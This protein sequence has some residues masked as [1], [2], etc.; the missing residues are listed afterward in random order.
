VPV[1][2]R[3]FPDARYIL[4]LRH[5]CD[6]LL[7]CF[8]TNFQINNAMANFLDLGDAA[9]LYDQTFAY[10]EKARATFNLPVREVVYERLVEDTT[11]ELRPLFDWLELDWPGD[12]QDH[13]EAA[14]ARGVVY[15]ASYAQV[16]EPIYTRA[17]GRWH[18]Y[19]AHLEPVLET[20]RPWT[21]KF[22]YSLEDGRIPGW[23]DNTGE[24][25]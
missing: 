4:A 21:E 20:M 16:T 10:W 2:Q 5:P 24:A 15:T 12:D 3:F 8:L 7:S 19:R 25:G 13:R 17:R 14:R 1:I 22:G 23:P 9:T 18:N 11:R 6:V